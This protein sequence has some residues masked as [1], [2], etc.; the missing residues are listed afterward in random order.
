V[1]IVVFALNG[2]NIVVFALNGEVAGKFRFESIFVLC[3]AH[4]AFC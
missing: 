1:N 3:K 4:E 2:V